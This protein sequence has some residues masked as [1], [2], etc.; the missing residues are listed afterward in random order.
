MKFIRG[1]ASSFL[2]AIGLIGCDSAPQLSPE[3]SLELATVRPLTYQDIQ[4]HNVWVRRQSSQYRPEPFTALPI[5]VKGIG[6]VKAVPNIAVITGEIKAKAQA[7]DEAVDKAAKIINAVQEALK[8]Q[9]AHLNFIQ[10]S[11]VEKRDEDCQRH[12][13]ESANR[14]NE[15][16]LDNRHNANIKAQIERGINT[17]T[18]PRAAKT[19]ITQKLCPVLETQAKLGFVVRIAPA[20]VAAD[21]INTLTQAGVEKVDL[22]GYDF[23]DYDALYKVAAAKAVKDAK[24]KAELIASR[25]GTQLTEITN[26]TVDPP[27]RTSRFGPQAMIITNHGNRSVAA[28]QYNNLG[29]ALINSGPNVDYI[30]TPAVYETVTETVVTQE[31]STELVTVPATYETVTETV[32]VQEASTELVAIPATFDSP[33]RV[34]ERIIP[35]VTKQ[36]TRRVVRQP[37]STVERAIPAVTKQVTKRVVKTPASATQRIVPENERASNALK[38]SLAGARTITVNAALTYNYKTPIDGTLPQPETSK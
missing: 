7:D 1:I 27:E 36:E 33:A 35:A 24:T 18:K 3:L 29:G 23:E 9:Q 4:A 26:F 16:V 10:I 2:L 11:A 6:R 38:M 19:R 8:D 20:S 31:A 5:E 17:K 32:V 25:A 28:G 30:I 21:M 14:H 13:I 12:N 15:I 37:A 34:V 22:Y